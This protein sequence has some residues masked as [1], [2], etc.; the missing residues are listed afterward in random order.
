MNYH[1]MNWVKHVFRFCLL[2]VLLT[3]CQNTGESGIQKP[4]SMLEPAEG[5]QDAR[6]FEIRECSEGHELLI[7]DPWNR[8]DTFAF[9]TIDKSFQEMERWAVF[10][11]TH[12]GFLDAL[13]E[14]D[15]VVGSTSPDRI[16]HKELREKYESGEILRIGTDMEYNIE[17]LHKLQPDLLIQS[18]FPGQKAKDSRIVESGIN[19]IYLMEW[20]EPTALGRAEWIRVFGLLLGKSEMADSIFRNVKVQYEQLRDLVNTKEGKKPQVLVGNSFKGTWYMP[21]GN[22]YL[23]ALAEDA[24]FSYP[25]SSTDERG[26]LP[27]SFELV[28]HEFKQ[29]EFWINVSAKDLD[30]LLKEDERYGLF[31]AF[32]DKHVYTFNKRVR[33]QIA[34][35]YWE[36]GVVNPH[37][38]LK[39]LIS[40]SFP[41]LIDNYELYYYKR[42]E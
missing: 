39:D 2:F 21:G 34:N 8:T 11:T 10:S 29:A 7:F 30:F 19:L 3:A 38:V 27:L 1:A 4:S 33:H 42:L 12:I 32:K 16:Y 25:Y 24:G 13:G 6:G 31:K 5:N 40:I 20:L 37:L 15:R 22:S 28:A 26:S 41:D 35:D 18:A 23:S 14:A 36:S 17:S 9:Y